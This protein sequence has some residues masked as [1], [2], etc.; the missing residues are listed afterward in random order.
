MIH[1]VRLSVCLLVLG[2]LLTGCAV[3]RN[4]PLSKSYHNVLA[5]YNGYFLAQQKLNEVEAKVWEAM[6]NDYNRVLPIFP[7][8]DTT[9]ISTLRPDLED[10]IKKASIPIQ[11]HKNS[12]WVDDSY[13]LIGKT[14][15]YQGEHE[16]AIRTFKY[17]NLTSKEDATKH[18]ALVWLMRMFIETRSYEEA[19]QVSDYLDKL[20][21]NEANY[22][23]HYLTRAHYLTVTG[24]APD[25][26]IDN[27]NQALPHL[28]R[29][30]ERSRLHFTLAQMHQNLGQDE[31]AYK[32][33]SAILRKNPPYELGF[34]S[35]LSLGLV[36][37]VGDAGD[38]ARIE[39]YF[40]KLLKDGK[41]LDYRDKIY[42]EMARFELKQEN[43]EPAL[44]H[45]RKSVQE[46]L[47]NPTQKAYSY[48]LAGR[49]Y[50]ENLKKYQQAHI[51]YDSALQVY[52]HDA[53]DYLAL[54]ERRDILAD[55]ATQ[56]TTIETEDSLQ[57]L[58]KMD[59]ASLYKRF[60]EIIALQQERQLEAQRVEEAR[61]AQ[62]LRGRGR[63]TSGPGPGMMMASLDDNAGGVW[64]F[65]NP[66]SLA[67]ARS[68][69]S[70]KW[71]DRALQDNW[72]RLNQR[73]PDPAAVAAAGGAAA[74]APPAVLDPQEQKQAQYQDFLQNIP[75][76]PELMAISQNK[77]EDALYNLAI[78]YQHKLNEPEQAMETY[79]QLVAKFPNT[80][81]KAEVL[82]S[83]FLLHRQAEDG[84]HVAFAEQVK[85]E[86]PESRFAQLI[87]NPDFEK[88]SSA[89]LLVI[90]QLYDSAFTFYENEN[91]QEALGIAN[92]LT[93]QYPGNELEDK[94]AFLRVLLAGRLDTPGT[95][96]GALM[97]FGQDFPS[98]PL[99]EKAQELLLT[100][101]DYE[102]GKLNREPDFLRKMAPPLP[103]LNEAEETPLA[104]AGAPAAVAS[105][106]PGP[107]LPNQPATSSLK[108]AVEPI[109]ETA[110]PAGAPAPAPPSSEEAAFASSVPVAEPVVSPYRVDLKAP[111]LFIVAYPKAE[112]SF[113]KMKEQFLAF[114]NKYHKSK[115]LEVSNAAYDDNLALLVFQ[116]FTDS[117]IA[118]AYASMQKTKSSPLSKVSEV[119][120]K[121]FVISAENLPVLLE[122][123]NMEEY[124]TFFQN[125]YSK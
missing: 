26:I 29:R 49:I 61:A 27:L 74:P 78:I 98:S 83:L 19:V 63:A 117:K 44:K 82:Y 92:H 101:A 1:I 12:R 47:S 119:A 70:R 37:Q 84:R 72:R 42:Y 87:D 111:H 28:E 106:V 56:F 99:Q 33:Y 71:G 16:D 95:F 102:A 6:E 45:L 100:F 121:T 3:E 89:D 114:N 97:Q 46:S 55:F 62:A 22:R 77:M 20:P 96:K 38:R 81:N 52:P 34:Y 76:T 124:E 48:L 116:S 104:E 108:E 69:F 79:E 9:F 93:V 35:K 10:I 18:E 94:V 65:D 113:E 51:Y 13:L 58:A 75:L 85:K 36:S 24:G 90:H 115:R 43:Y 15:Y 103:E 2:L 25:R 67:T 66:T 23:E 105:T 54:A 14:R 107:Q 53:E 123:Q 21:L 60:D 17:V 112:A 11:R 57:V 80:P 88:I 8:F 91:Y 7:T 39:R 30:D 120:Y 110:D 125:N 41:N 109:K 59:T 73:T 32:H 68:E 40:R 64:Y 86:F 50:F 5:H 118:N 122:R 4:N 31:E